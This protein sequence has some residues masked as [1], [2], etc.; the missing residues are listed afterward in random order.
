MAAGDSDELV[1]I[2]MVGGQ[3][4]MSSGLGKLIWTRVALM[5]LGAGVMGVV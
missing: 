5:M 2:E 3:K 4:M 1:A